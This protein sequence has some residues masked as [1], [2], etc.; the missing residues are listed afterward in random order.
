VVGVVTSWEGYPI[1]HYVFEGNTKDETTVAN[2]VKELNSLYN[3]EETIFVGDRGMITKLNIDTIT[4]LGFDYIMGIKHRQNE[5]TKLLFSHDKVKDCDYLR[6]KSL[7]VQEINFANKEFI[8][9]KS[10]DILGYKEADIAINEA[11]V[12][13]KDYIEKLNDND[14]VSFSNV[15]NIVTPFTDDLKTQ[16]RIHQILKRYEKKYSQTTRLIICLNDERKKMQQNIGLK[17]F[18]I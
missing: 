6:Y 12:T 16:K 3:I 11:L 9:L 13:L 14:K 5:I 8:L 7:L 10:I 18:M 15:K 17:N 4:A 2:A 1:K